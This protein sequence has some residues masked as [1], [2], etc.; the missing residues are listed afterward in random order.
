MVRVVTPVE[1]E[2]PRLTHLQGALIVF[3]TGVFFS[4]GGLAFRS[5]EDVGPW[6]YLVFRGLGMLGAATV[7]LGVRYR[8]RYDDLFGNIEPGH[9]IAGLVLGGMNTLFIV[10][11]SLATVAFVLVLQTLA[12]LAAAYFSWLIMGERPSGS[13]L[14]ATAISM[15]GVAVM[16]SGS[17]SD[18]LSPYGLLAAL[19]P[20]GFGYY[21]TLIRSAKRIDPS[22]PLVIAGLTLLMVG[23]A[24]V[25]GGGGFEA[26]PREAAVGLFAGSVLLAVP[27]AVFNIAQ[28][29][30]PSPEAAILIMG[31]II[32]APLWVWLFV[33]EEASASTLAGGAII[34][35]AVVWVTLNRIPRRGRRP[36][37]T[38]G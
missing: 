21:T 23:A 19:I 14:I 13:V 5:V 29:V 6:E 26:T 15:V 30:V 32:L 20:L 9:I 34:L 7:V 1:R 11:L 37:T 12:P 18:D 8:K 2:L 22:V 24:V 25:L 36:I 31:E 28:R 10:S 16:V 35:I 4:F 3:G 38:R 27:L 33:G 17:I